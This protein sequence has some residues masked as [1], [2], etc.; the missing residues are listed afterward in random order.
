VKYRL[1]IDLRPLNIHCEEFKTK[2]ETLAKLGTLI[3]EG[4]T[5]SFMS[6]D[7]ADAYNCLQIDPEFQQYFGFNLRG[8]KFVM[9]ALPFG[10][11]QSPYCFCTAM[12]TLVR[13]LRSPDLPSAAEQSGFLETEG[14]GCVAPP[15]EW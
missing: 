12:K 3:S 11:N 14:F 7:L 4:E 8:R 9:T 5:V 13:L 2:Y 15:P 10:W 6:F 1:I